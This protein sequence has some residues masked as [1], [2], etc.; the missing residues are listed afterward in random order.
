[1]SYESV[2]CSQPTFEYPLDAFRAQEPMDI[3]LYTTP[4]HRQLIP[5]ILKI[6]HAIS[7][8]SPFV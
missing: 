1:M 6:H 4:F 3:L 5:F 8:A 2:H 7:I